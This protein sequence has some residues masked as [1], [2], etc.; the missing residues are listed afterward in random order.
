VGG[1][2]IKES[3]HSWHLESWSPPLKR[4]R[5]LA[6]P[7][8]DGRTK[9]ARRGRLPKAMPG[10]PPLPRCMVPLAKRVFWAAFSAAWM[11]SRQAKILD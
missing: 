6:A 2:P 10:A 9:A 5:A 3:S 4:A 1:N 11:D 8:T 7:A